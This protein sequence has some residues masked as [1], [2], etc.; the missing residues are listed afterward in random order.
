MDWTRNPATQPHPEGLEE[1]DLPLISIITPSF[2]QGPFLETTIRSVVLQGYPK[3]EYVVIDGG[4]T[5]DSLSII[6]HYSDFIDYWVHEPDQGQSHAINKGYQQCAGTLINWLNSDDYLMPRAL[7]EIATMWVKQQGFDVL[8]GAQYHLKASTKRFVQ[9]DLQQESE[10]PINLE[11]MLYLQPCTYIRKD[12]F[13]K[14]MV[15]QDLHYIM[16]WE[17]FGRLIS[18]KKRSICYT[19][20][21]LATFR[22]HESSKS[23]SEHASFE[24]EKENL[25]AQLARQWG[26]K[27]LLTPL[28]SGE[29]ENESR[30]ISWPDGCSKSVRC[31]LEYFLLLQAIHLI[32]ESKGRAARQ[33]LHHIPFWKLTKEH[34]VLY[35]RQRIKSWL[36]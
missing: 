24:E 31:S 12:L 2:N 20:K 28:S 17:M 4:S 11:R 23:S 13:G 19:D 5:D 25:Y 30:E 26:W 34:Q 16:D 21:A 3:L 14:E 6:E 1:T 32:D 10:L 36:R 15:R 8:M 33:Y 22:F 7:W 18:E 29:K 9:A 27:D 35:L